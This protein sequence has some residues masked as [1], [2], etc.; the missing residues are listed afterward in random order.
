MDWLGGRPNAS[1]RKFG[2]FIGYFEK[3]PG[4][5]Q[6]QDNIIR[7][8][9]E[10]IPSFSLSPSQERVLRSGFLGALSMA[11]VWPEQLPGVQQPRRLQVQAPSAS[12]GAAA[13]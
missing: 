5:S 9:Q 1:L 13:Q 3:V 6:A 10:R 7:Q 4:A 2:K 12:L 8:T 11:A